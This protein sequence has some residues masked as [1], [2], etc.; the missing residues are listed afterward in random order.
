MTKAFVVALVLLPHITYAS[1]S[2]ERIPNSQTYTWSILSGPRSLPNGQ[3]SN[4]NASFEV[5]TR[6]TGDA[7]SVV[8]ENKTYGTGSPSPL[9]SLTN[10]HEIVWSGP[11]KVL[12]T[13]QNNNPVPH[14]VTRIPGMA[15]GDW[16]PGTKIHYGSGTTGTVNED[17]FLHSKAYSSTAACGLM[18]PE[19]DEI[20]RYRVTIRYPQNNITIE[21][22]VTAKQRYRM[23]Q[24]LGVAVEPATINFGTVKWVGVDTGVSQDLK[25]SITGAAGIKVNVTYTYTSETGANHFV[26][27]GSS[28]IPFTTDV[29]L[30]GGSAAVLTPVRVFAS[31]VGNVRGR[32][33]VTAQIP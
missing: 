33:Q 28:A 1:C 17:T 20:T 21:G 15:G 11:R 13:L 23:T 16:D 26:L 7:P 3:K 25:T 4:G 8:D 30:D 31:E 5:S 6:V 10:A 27:L 9:A 32:L 22:E 14:G 18:K 2:F 24:N 19:F 12:L 29:R